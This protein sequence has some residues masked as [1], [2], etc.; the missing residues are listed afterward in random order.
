MADV[1][2]NDDILTVEADQVAEDKG[3]GQK[4]FT[5]SWS[6]LTPNS[7]FP[8]CSVPCIAGSQHGSYGKAS[9]SRAGTGLK[10][11]VGNRQTDRLVDGD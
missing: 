2:R 7:D 5:T 11:S 8:I 9:S 1:Q 6:Q 10:R 4:V 3:E